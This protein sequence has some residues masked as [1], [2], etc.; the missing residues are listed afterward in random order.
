VVDVLEPFEIR[1]GNTSSIHEQIWGNNDVFSKKNFFSSKSGWA[2]SSFENGFTVDLGSIY[3]MDRLLSSSWDNEIDLLFIVGHM[4]VNIDFSSIVSSKGTVGNK[5]SFC[6][7]YI[8]SFG[9]MNGT[10]S[11]DNSCDDSTILFNEFGSPISDVSETLESESFSFN[12]KG[13]SV[14]SV[15]KALCVQ[16][17]TDSIVDT[18]S[19]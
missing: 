16:A 10:V 5:V 15:H 1:A 6:M 3:F 12:S 7:L 18:E 9:I 11:F 14:T 2:I 13:S 4:I 17:F 19:C 8:N